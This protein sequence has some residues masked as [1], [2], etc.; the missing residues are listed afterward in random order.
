MVHFP[1]VDND[2]RWMV[3]LKSV[4]ADGFMIPTNRKALIDTGTSYIYGPR[5]EVDILNSYIANHLDC[6]DL[7]NS[8]LPNVTFYFGKAAYAYVLTAEDYIHVENEDYY[9]GSCISKFYPSD[10]DFWI[11]GDTFM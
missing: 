9:Y 4:F 3:K 7:T 10:D 1:V 2:G 5:H 6:S 8:D 11:L